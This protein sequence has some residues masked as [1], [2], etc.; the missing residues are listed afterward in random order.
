MT[1]PTIDWEDLLQKNRV[2]IRTVIAAHGARSADE[3][4]EVFQNVALA[5]FSQKAPIQDPD[6]VCAWLHSLAANQTRLYCRSRGRYRKRV[7]GFRDE[8]PDAD[9]SA[10]PEPIDW[11]LDRERRTRV[12]EALGRLTADV[13]EIF[14]MKYYHNLNYKEIAE[15]LETSVSAVQAKL[16][17]ARAALKKEILQ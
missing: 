8:N 10:E 9:R 16:H 3:V 4:D 17:R 14:L 1:A 11:L 5:V 12:R 2:W 6:K 7:D 13:R 15:E